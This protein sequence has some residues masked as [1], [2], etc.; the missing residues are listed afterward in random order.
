MYRFPLYS[1]VD[2]GLGLLRW[3][4][5]GFRDWQFWHCGEGAACVLI[6]CSLIILIQR[7]G[8]N[9]VSEESRGVLYS[10]TFTAREMLTWTPKLS[11]ESLTRFSGQTGQRGGR[12]NNVSDTS[13][14]SPTTRLFF[15]TRSKSRKRVRWSVQSV[16]N[17]DVLWSR[18]PL[19]PTLFAVSLT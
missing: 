3:R 9:P 5:E 8:L 10:P 7:S 16:W 6:S 12:D 1:V 4:L 17:M 13:H 15:Q 14:I 18:G 19:H 2:G 11:L